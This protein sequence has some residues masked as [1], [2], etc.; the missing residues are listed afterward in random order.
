MIYRIKAFWESVKF[1][2][3]LIIVSACWIIAY[4]VRFEWQYFKQILPVTKGTPPFGRYSFLVIFIL[5]TWGVLFRLTG[6]YKTKGFASI[7][8]EIAAVLRSNLIAVV[9][10]NL[11]CFFAMEVKPSR[12]VF[13]IFFVTSSVALMTWRI[14]FRIAVRALSKNGIMQ[15]RILVVGTGPLAQ[16]FVNRAKVYENM[17][18]KVIG[19]LTDDKSEVNQE[20]LGIPV[21][22]T[23]DEV[24]TIVE[25]TK[26][27]EVVVALP[28][29]APDRLSTILAN[30]SQEMVDLKVVHDIGRFRALNIAVENFEG[31]PITSLKDTPLY[32]WKAIAKRVFDFVVALILLIIL[33]PLMLAIAIIIKLT[34]KG[35][36]FYKQ[37]RMG[38]DGTRFMMWKFRTMRT[39]AEAQTGPVWAKEKDPRVTKVGAILRKTSLDELPQLINVL[40]GD[41]SLVGPRPERPYFI[42][43]FRTT[44]PK[45]MLRHKVKAGMTGWA[46]VNGWRGNTSIEKRIEH[47][48]Y[49][50][51][52]WS[53]WLDI[54]ILWLT[55]WKGFVSKHAY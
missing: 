34:S 28:M 19:F 10:F 18:I 31:L 38:L 29:D 47:D 13:L 44:V 5:L 1:L 2:V 27:D 30:L 12:V 39:D 50:I 32:G 23:C 14:I 46:Q 8:R 42:E 51:E 36:V 17:G 33:F 16:E 35:P 37:E 49:Y 52:N 26:T 3:D 55:I 6:L 11:I 20:I 25:N 45:Y 53:F 7:L 21:L 22:G 54:K 43:Q 9:V 41:M 40:K 4:F 15:R 48:I 24:E